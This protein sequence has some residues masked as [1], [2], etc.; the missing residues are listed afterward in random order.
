MMDENAM[1]QRTR[2]GLE[3]VEA[4]RKLLPQIRA[5]A[6]EIES[7]QRIPESLLEEM[8]GLGMFTVFLPRELGGGV[9]DQTSFLETVELTSWG[10][11]SVG[12][13]LCQQNLVGQYAAWLD[14]VTAREVFAKEPSCTLVGTPVVSGTATPVEG[15]YRVTGRWSYLSGSGH[16]TG[17][18][19]SANVI[20][21]ETGEPACGEDGAAP[22][23]RMFVPRS[24]YEIAPGSWDVTG[25]RGTLSGDGVLDGVF[26]PERRTYLA[27]ATPKLTASLSPISPGAALA[28]VA[29]GCAKRA[30]D[31]FVD[32]MDVK[33]KREY[34]LQRKVKL[35]RDRPVV[36]SQL[37]RN[38]ARVQAA[39]SWLLALVQ[40]AETES[41]ETGEVS[42]TTDLDIQLARVHAPTEA[43]EATASIYNLGGTAAIKRGPIE[44]AYRDLL[45][46]S[47][48]VHLSEM[49]FEVVGR[50]LAAPEQ[51]T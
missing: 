28:F 46:M 20:D 39:R 38:R 18:W 49:Q 44:G 9:V 40:R 48:Q 24:D 34:T 45:T 35:L 16:A 27:D 13:C 4:A 5:S 51:D 17:A 26:V 30:Y 1:P 21:H 50:S 2:D 10:N 11:G 43:R 41:V 8:G 12:W 31:E 29:L 32:L 47:A 14:E 23:V 6:E 33:G 37:A 22:A 19:L 42:T 36:L 25:L 7:E 3:L 15:G